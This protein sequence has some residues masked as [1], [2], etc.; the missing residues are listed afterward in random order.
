MQNGPEAIPFAEVYLSTPIEVCEQRDPRKLYAR[1][2]AGEIRD[3]TGVSAPF[4]PPE[5]PEL[6]L[7][8]SRTSVGEALTSL[9][10]HLEPRIGLGAGH[11]TPA[12]GS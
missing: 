3:F 12:R 4:E 6:A 5:R 8:T 9:L 10:A 11:P 2:R 7:D 1:A